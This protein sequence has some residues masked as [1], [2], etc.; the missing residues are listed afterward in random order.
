[1]SCSN[2]KVLFKNV[3]E[4]LNVEIPEAVIQVGDI[5]DV[6][7]T[8]L[9]SQSTSI[10]SPTSLG[11]V[12]TIRNLEARKLDGFLVDRLGYIDIPIIGKIKA[13]TLTCSSLRDSI[14]SKSKEYVLNPNVRVM[15][16]NF[17]VSVMGEVKSPGTFD[18]V[19]QKMSLLELIS[20]AGGLTNSANPS[21]VMIIRD[22]NN[23]VE[24]QY[25]D[26]TSLE[27]INSEYYYLKQNDEI[28]ILPDKL[29]QVFD[30]GNLRYFNG[31]LA[32]TLVAII[33]LM[34]R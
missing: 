23:S 6:N 22:F 19:N 11:K 31:L 8:S 27:F 9:N 34:N 17:R 28:Y 25:I 24:T 14:K 29:S 10:F 3:P 26:L 2:N 30:Y 15:I 7:I 5:L 1:M 33:N 18:V 32:A 12:G 4:H 13:T 16:L 20:N 21:R